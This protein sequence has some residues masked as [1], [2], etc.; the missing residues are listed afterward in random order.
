MPKSFGHSK[1]IFILQKKEGQFEKKLLYN[2]GQIMKANVFL[3][4]AHHPGCSLA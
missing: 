2:F 3:I 1:N 4:T